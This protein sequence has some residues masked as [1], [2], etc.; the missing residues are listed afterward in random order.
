MQFHKG[1]LNVTKSTKD[2]TQV[3]KLIHKGL[4][5]QRMFHT[6]TTSTDLP[7][8]LQTLYTK[9]PNVE[10]LSHSDQNIKHINENNKG[11]IT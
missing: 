8:N 6:G 10:Q 3:S 7:Y 1:S 5:L 11:V 9:V 2:G 4:Q